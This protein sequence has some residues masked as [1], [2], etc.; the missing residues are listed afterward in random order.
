MKKIIYVCDLSPLFCVGEPSTYS[1][2]PYKSV[3]DFEE[4]G[5]GGGGKTHDERKRAILHLVGQ[6]NFW[7]LYPLK[8]I[9]A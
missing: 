5:G 6:R 4:G 2:V 3:F 1:T 9:I 7:T 8:K